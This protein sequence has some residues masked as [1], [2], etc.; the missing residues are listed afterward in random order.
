MADDH[1]N[2]G[3]AGKLGQIFRS[4]LKAPPSAT[5]HSAAGPPM[6]TSAQQAP[7]IIQNSNGPPG[8]Q[9]LADQL[10]TAVNAKVEM[11]GKLDHQKTE[12]THLWEQAQRER[13]TL[14]T[15]L[16]EALGKLNAA[17]DQARQVRSRQE[18]LAR[19]E[20]VNVDK[21]AQLNLKERELA[22]QL[23]AVTQAITRQHAL[24]QENLR[25]QGANAQARSEAQRL[26]D[27][28]QKRKHEGLKVG[29]D[30]QRDR[31]SF[32]FCGNLIPRAK[33]PK[34]NVH[35]GRRTAFRYESHGKSAG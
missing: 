9:D 27:E 11:Q 34:L 4:W 14:K 25:L 23:Q 2:P 15:K 10:R 29:D 21:Q 17:E 3:A 5:P 32:R 6:A 18:E 19:Q 26:R 1:N 16:T 24:Q 8:L 12:L 31:M 30:H 35:G 22:P 7:P 20:K 28:A 33:D 13:D